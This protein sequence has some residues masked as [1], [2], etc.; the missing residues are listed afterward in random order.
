MLFAS[1]AELVYASAVRPSPTAARSPSRG[2]TSLVC[3]GRPRATIRQRSRMADA[4]SPCYGRACSHGCSVHP[5]TWVGAATRGSRPELGGGGAGG[6]AA[7]H[8][9]QHRPATPP[10]TL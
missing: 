8:L 5:P 4:T 1:A 9:V 7:A 10:Q 3:D 6:S 2:A